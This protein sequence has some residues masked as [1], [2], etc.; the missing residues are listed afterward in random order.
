MR[1]TVTADEAGTRLDKLLV[2]HLTAVGRAQ[3]KRLFEE[4]R[5]HLVLANPRGERM[6]RA[7]KGDVC[8]A[9][10]VFELG[11]EEQ[12]SEALA[13]EGAPLEVLLETDQ[14]VVVEKPA[15]QPSAP[16]QPGE[17]G[18]LANALLGRYPEMKGV[19]FSLR[20]P[21][22]CHRL[23]TATSGLLVAARSTAAFEAITRGLKDH[24][25]D[26]KYLLLCPAK[27]LPES[28]V[29][30]I[31]LAPH[32]KDKKRMLACVH[33]RDQARNAPKPATT[34]YRV[35][36]VHG[37]VALVEATAPSARRHQIRAH[38][39]AIGHPLY[40]DALYRGAPLEGLS[41]HALHA[42]RIAWPGDAV[43]PAFVVTSQ[44]PEDLAKLV[45]SPD[46]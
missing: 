8:A 33:E 46:A 40:G 39:A 41:R 2:K 17:R 37:E 1:I 44:L 4:D 13:D 11:V 26:K 24:R 21:G 7:R 20:E 31:P 36:R 29:I 34:S 30:D 43:V 19:G 5:V 16:L 3:V 32:P 23:D 25:L 28:G 6:Q 10:Q 9:G 12:S 35:V 42:N 18:A 45:P 15:G 27:D 38:F 22:L 14:I